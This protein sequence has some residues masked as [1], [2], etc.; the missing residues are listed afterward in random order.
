WALRNWDR[1]TVAEAGVDTAPVWSQMRR[2][3]GSFDRQAAVDY[4]RT[5]P[6]RSLGR[7]SDRGTDVHGVMEAIAKGEAVPFVGPGR[8]PWVRAVQRF[9][10][11][12]RPVPV[13]VEVSVYS[14][15]RTMQYAGTLDLI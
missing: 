3:D 13:W 14:R 6:D 7:A 12:F 1:T 11:D 10:Q 2:P 15:R 9:F 4:I 8:E 5:A